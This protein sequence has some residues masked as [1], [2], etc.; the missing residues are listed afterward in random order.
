MIV[1]VWRQ[2]DAREISKA[3]GAAWARSKG[4]LF[5]ETSAKTTVGIQEVFEEVVNKIM[6]NPTL[7]KNT[8]PGH[9]LG[10]ADLKAAESAQ[11]SS[12]PNGCC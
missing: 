6:E 7:L 11:Q 8:A 4:M 10:N 5:I 12:Q 1:T 3:D 2:A 9:S